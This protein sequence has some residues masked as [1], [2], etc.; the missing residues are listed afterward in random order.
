MKFTTGMELITQIPK[1][2]DSMAHVTKRPGSMAHVT[3]I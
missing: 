3:I 1:R 2:P